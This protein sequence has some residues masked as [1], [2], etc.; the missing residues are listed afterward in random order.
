M[1]VFNSIFMQTFIFCPYNVL[2]S[3]F[4]MDGLS[5]T[6]AQHNSVISSTATK[7][8]HAPT[9][10]IPIL[11]VDADQQTHVYLYLYLI[12]IYVHAA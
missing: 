3:R 6:T 1:L 11:Y 5:T 10:R 2:T 12:Y 8:I 4:P 7:R 9:Y